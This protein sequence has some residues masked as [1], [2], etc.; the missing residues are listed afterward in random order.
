MEGRK[1]IFYGTRCIDDCAVGVTA[2]AATLDSHAIQ[3]DFC[4]PRALSPH[5]KAES[6][7]KAQSDIGITKEIINSALGRMHEYSMHKI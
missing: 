2:F 1:E 4:R 3:L 6:A 7:R 5:L